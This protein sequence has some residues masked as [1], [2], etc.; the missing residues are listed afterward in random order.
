[1]SVPVDRAQVRHMA[2]LAR[3]A[4]TDE[5]EVALAAHFGRVLD[6]VAEL[7]RVDVTG[8]DP[9]LTPT[10]SVLALAADE[11]RVPGAPGDLEVPARLIEN[12]PAFDAGCFITP[13]G[14][15]NPRA[16]DPRSADPRGG[17]L[18]A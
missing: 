9:D 6:F 2:R 7:E 18:R 15:S 5:E 1:M 16:E 4:V 17:D 12:A 13:S 8:V 11:P 3:L 10:C 14:L